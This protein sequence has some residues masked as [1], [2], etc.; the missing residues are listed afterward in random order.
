MEKKRSA[1]APTDQ[2]KQLLLTLEQLL[3]RLLTALANDGG[4]SAQTQA[5]A[6]ELLPHARKLAR[7]GG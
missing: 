3:L 5:A 4:V 6:L 1:A 7:E 2:R